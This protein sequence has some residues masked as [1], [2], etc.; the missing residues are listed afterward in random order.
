MY[1]CKRVCD[2]M[3]KYDVNS[4]TINECIGTFDPKQDGLAAFCNRTNCEGLRRAYE[5][6]HKKEMTVQKVNIRRVGHAKHYGELP[7]RVA[8]ML[9][10]EQFIKKYHIVPSMNARRGRLQMKRL[11]KGLLCT[12]LK[13]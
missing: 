5:G 12:A 1:S 6:K 3:C 10:R 11:S 2:N 7:S 9:E 4:G 8:Y 13:K